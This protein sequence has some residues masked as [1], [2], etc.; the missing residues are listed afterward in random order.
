MPIRVSQAPPTL[1]RIVASAYQDALI[2][3]SQ[4]L[5]ITWDIR[6]Q[7]REWLANEVRACARMRLAPYMVDRAV[8]LEEVL[9]VLNQPRLPGEIALV[10]VSAADNDPHPIWDARENLLFRFVHDVHHWQQGADA[11]FAGELAT[12]RMVLE[13]VQT[14]ELR[15]VLASEIIGQAAFRLE[16]GVFP[17]QQVIA[18]N[19]LGLLP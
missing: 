12:L 6:Q 9:K 2:D 17:D 7:A 13:S 18:A 16:F 8:T 4:R 19:V 5:P 15:Q 3:H 10:P 1:Q 11:T 14:K